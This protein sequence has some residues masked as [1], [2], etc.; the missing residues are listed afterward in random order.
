MKKSLIV[1]LTVCA[2]WIYW[3]V[4]VLDSIG[5]GL[6]F[7]LILWSTIY[8]GYLYFKRRCEKIKIN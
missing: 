8:G 5:L 2:F 4:F 3:V 6:V 7:G 1:F